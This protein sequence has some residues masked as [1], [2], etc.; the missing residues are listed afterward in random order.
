MMG[1]TTRNDIIVRTELGEGTGDM[2]YQ[3]SDGKWWKKWEGELVGTG[4]EIRELRIE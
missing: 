2:R 1:G 3:T 4:D